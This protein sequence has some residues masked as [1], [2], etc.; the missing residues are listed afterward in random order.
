MKEKKF[1]RCICCGK[2]T[3]NRH[4]GWWIH[5]GCKKELEAFLILWE[6]ERV[7]LK[8]EIVDWKKAFSL[9]INE[10]EKIEEYNKELEQ[11]AFALFTRR[12]GKPTWV[13]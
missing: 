5:S 6:K 9:F 7:P 1:V 11:K 2:F 13:K 4:K 10:P 12:Y 3:I 8:L